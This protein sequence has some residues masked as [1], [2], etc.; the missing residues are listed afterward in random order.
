MSWEKPLLGDI[1]KV[2]RGEKG[3]R[4]MLLGQTDKYFL[5]SLPFCNPVGLEQEDLEVRLKC[6]R[7]CICREF[8]RGPSTSH[9]RFSFGAWFLLSTHKFKDN[10]QSFVRITTLPGIHSNQQC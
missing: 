7:A 2:L 8:P 4:I 6:S 10:F 5:V 9:P 1:P 3:Q